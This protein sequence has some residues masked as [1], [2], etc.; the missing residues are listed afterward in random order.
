MNQVSAAL[1][2]LTGDAS[3]TAF[4]ST[5]SDPVSKVDDH[6]NS[7][8]QLSDTE[9]ELIAQ[10]LLSVAIHDDSPAIRRQRS[11][12]S[13]GPVILPKG[14]RIA[15]LSS[16]IVSF[17]YLIQYQLVNNDNSSLQLIN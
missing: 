15:Y 12:L 3:A 10:T 8:F 5:W 17:Q 2:Q 7:S 1:N 9:N 16:F 13:Q 4:Q 14:L 11:S 6:N